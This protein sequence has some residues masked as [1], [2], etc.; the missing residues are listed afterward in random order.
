M[1]LTLYDQYWLSEIKSKFS[2]DSWAYDVTKDFND[3]GQE[4]LSILREWFLSHPLPSKGKKKHMKNALESLNNHDHL[5]AVN[6]LC[7]FRFMCDLAVSPQALQEGKGK[8]PDFKC[9]SSGVEFYCEVTTLNVSSKDSETNTYGTG[10]PLDQ[11]TEISRIIRKARDEKAEQL[12][13]GERDL[14]PMVFVVF[15]Y[16][17]FSGFGTERP[18]AIA[19]ALLKTPKGLQA[20]QPH[21]S[22]IIYVERYVWRGRSRIRASQS[23]VY[24]NP[25]ADRPLP[26][27]IF[28]CFRQYTLDSYSSVE[29]KT[30]DIV[31]P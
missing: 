11:D 28:A 22:A 24:H 2:P 7:W 23:A 15:D 29:A 9:T 4:Y 19:D 26:L 31:V 10:T 6:E 25:F 20:M 1:K 13:F 18:I 30:V 8:T 14:K 12:K 21:L 16:S 5:G 27:D 17:K 3:D